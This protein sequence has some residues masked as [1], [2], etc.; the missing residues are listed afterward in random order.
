MSAATIAAAWVMGA[1]LITAQPV[2]GMDSE[3]P[4]L[5]AVHQPTQIAAGVLR[6]GNGY[7]NAWAG[8]VFSTADGRFSLTVGAVAGV[9]HAEYVA[10]RCMRSQPAP[11]QRP[12]FAK[13]ERSELLPLVAASVRLP[14]DDRSALR[15][16]AWPIRLEAGGTRAA[17]GLSLEAAL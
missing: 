6:N 2:T 15:V 12:C 16:S 14:L 5:Y 13:H 11:V 1:H 4:G 9:Q 17:V 3:T 7:T 8:R 10:Q